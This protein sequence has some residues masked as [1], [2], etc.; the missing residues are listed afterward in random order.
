MKP[1]PTW[2]YLC[3]ALAVRRC[4]ECGQ[5]ICEQQS[6]LGVDAKGRKHYLCVPC[7]DRQQ[8]DLTW[9]GRQ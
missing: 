7:D 5:P 4:G 3:G 9:H 8:S 6:R 2:C 1:Q